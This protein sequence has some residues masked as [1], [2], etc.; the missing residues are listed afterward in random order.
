MTPNV[1]NLHP[2]ARTATATVGDHAISVLDAFEV[3]AAYLTSAPG[4][5]SNRYRSAAVSKLHELVAT[6]NLFSV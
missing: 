1:S 6:V 4:T 3:I 5:E 2:T